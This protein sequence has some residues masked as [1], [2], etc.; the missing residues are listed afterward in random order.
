MPT[1]G[2]V[3]PC[4]RQAHFLAEA[5][6]SVLAQSRVPDEVIVVDDGSPDDVAA[7][8]DAYPTVR[9]IAQENRGLSEARNAGLRACSSE[10]IVFLD[11][12]DRLLP[13]ALETGADALDACEPCAFAWGFNRPM[14][15]RGELLPLPPTSYQGDTTY[16]DLLERNI[17]GAPVGVIFRTAH[18]RAV[19]GFSS[20]LKNLEDYEL[21]LRMARRYPFRCHG[22]LIADY[23]RHGANMSGDLDAML[24]GILRVLDL[25]EPFVAGHPRLRRALRRGRRD[26][27]RR[28]D[29]TRRI[30]DIG[31][32]RRERRWLAAAGAL[33]A[34]CVRYPSLG[35]RTVAN[36]MR[37]V[38]SPHRPRR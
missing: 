27:W 1:I 2:V 12:D 37:R 30:L 28:F 35:V 32:R 33:L 10:Y 23:R 38:A 22:Q 25:Q 5:I 16:A 20:D 21:Y 26:A 19:G 7:V 8:V 13:N 11:S 36:R 24:H 9:C 18:L 4:Y 31:A 6:D 29:G 17:V 3:I 15:E 14:D 34:L